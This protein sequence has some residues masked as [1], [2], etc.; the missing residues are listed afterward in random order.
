M[1]WWGKWEKPEIRSVRARDRGWGLFPPCSFA[2]LPPGFFCRRQYCW[3]AK[4]KHVCPWVGAQVAERAEELSLRL[5][6]L[7]GDTGTA[8]PPASGKW[9]LVQISHGQLPWVW[10][11]NLGCGHVPSAGWGKKLHPG[12]WSVVTTASSWSQHEMDRMVQGQAVPVHLSGFAW[13]FPTTK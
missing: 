2:L 10:A 5:C 13:Y 9:Q 11:G 1:R 6:R 7:I 8:G 4:A 3:W 12:S